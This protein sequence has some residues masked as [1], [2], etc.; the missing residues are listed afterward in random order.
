MYILWFL[1]RGKVCCLHSEDGLVGNRLWRPF[2]IG[3]CFC[4]KIHFRL[5]E[6]EWGGSPS[7]KKMAVRVKQADRF[8]VYKGSVTK[9]S[10]WFIE[11]TAHTWEKS[12]GCWLRLRRGTL[13]R[14]GSYSPRQTL[15]DEQAWKEKQ[16]KREILA[17][18]CLESIHG[19]MFSR[20][21]DTERSVVLET[22]FRVISNR[23]GIRYV[24]LAEGRTLK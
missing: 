20:Q 15:T 10:L 14:W 3:V 21:L 1:T 18:R 9:F 16:E 24:K 11:S 8:G 12:Q 2:S 4:S 6:I 5:L 13:H 19:G 22:D 23:V 17:L 7:K